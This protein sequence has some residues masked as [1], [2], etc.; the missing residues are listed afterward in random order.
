[1]TLVALPIIFG[2]ARDGQRD[3]DIPIFVQ[4]SRV[5]VETC[6]SPRAP[7]DIADIDRDLQISI[8]REDKR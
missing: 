7:Y 8:A 4:L 5:Q 6:R 3:P 1:M 2:S